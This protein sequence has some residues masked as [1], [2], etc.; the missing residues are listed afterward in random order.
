[1][2]EEIQRLEKERSDATTKIFRLGLEIAV[3]FA[4]PAILVAVLAAPRLTTNVTFILLVITFVLSW[5]VIIARYK[6]VHKKMTALDARIR[7]LKQQ[8]HN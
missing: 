5:V 1:M 4:V 8:E 3:I 6:K 2:Q 7:E